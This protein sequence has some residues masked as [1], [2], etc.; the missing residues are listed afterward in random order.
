MKLA[1]PNTV[2]FELKLASP[3]TKSFELNL[4]FPDT[5]IL[6][7]KLASP[8]TVTFELKL[9]SP[10]TVMFLLKLASPITVIFELKLASPPTFNCLAIPAPPFTTSAP[11]VWLV[12]GVVPCIVTLLEVVAAPILMAV[13]APPK[14]IDVVGVS[15][16]RDALALVVVIVPLSTDKF[17]PVPIVT[18]DVVVFNSEPDMFMLPVTSNASSGFVF[19][20]PT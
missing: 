3:V 5:S 4:A 17:I 12:D 7:L 1:S 10:I 11:L 16:K 6:E 15:L 13:A 2:I 18:F 8:D 14:F 19:A 9:A 20:M